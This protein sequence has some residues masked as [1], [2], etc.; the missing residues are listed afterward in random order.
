MK[1]GQSPLLHAIDSQLR[2]RANSQQGDGSFDIKTLNF[3]F[4]CLANIAPTSPVLADKILRETS[5]IS[6]LGM[7]ESNLNVWELELLENTYRLL[8]YLITPLT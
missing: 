1:N 3:I 7:L 4:E 6:S 8:K 2:S 5:I